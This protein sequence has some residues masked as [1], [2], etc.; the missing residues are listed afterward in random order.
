MTQDQSFNQAKDHLA[1][2]QLQDRAMRFSVSSQTVELAA[3][4]VGCPAAQIAKTLSFK[5]AGEAV[6]IVAAGD[7]RINNGKFKAFFQTKAVML[8]PDEVER[9]VG[10][11]V[12]GVCPFGVKEGVRVYLDQSLQRFDTVYPAC[13]TGDSAVKLSPEE[14]F[15]ASGALSYVDVC[16]LPEDQA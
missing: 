14:L 7:A 13:G 6:L 5:V 8:S 2:F 3:L 16:K 10:Y 11:S 1:R 9:M 15:L 4:A 12:G